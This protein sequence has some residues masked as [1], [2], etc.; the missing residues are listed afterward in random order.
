MN[1]VVADILRT[2]DDHPQD[3][4]LD[5]LKYVTVAFKFRIIR[6]AHLAGR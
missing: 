2:V 3:T 4:I 1:L 5:T 6:Q